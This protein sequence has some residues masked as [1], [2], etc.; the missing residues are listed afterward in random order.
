VADEL[1][2]VRPTVFVNGTEVSKA[3]A[4]AMV[5]LRVTKTLGVPSY[6]RLAYLVDTMGDGLAPDQV[7]AKLGDE[8][9]IDVTDGKATWTVFEGVVVGLGVDLDTGTSQQVVVEAYDQLYKLG[10]M[11]HVRTFVDQK[12][13]DAVRALAGDAGLALG[14][15]DK[16]LDGGVRPTAYQYGTAYAYIDALV[17]DAGCE[18]FVEAKKLEVR[19]RSASSPTYDLAIGRNLLSFNSR[20]SATEHVGEVTVTGWDVQKKEAI[21]GTAKLDWASAKSSIG[22]TANDPA[23]SGGIGGTK[24]FA[25]PRPVADQQDA[26][27]VAKGILSRRASEML[28]ARGE[29]EPAKEL[30]PGVLLNVTGFGENWDGGYYCTGIEHVWGRGSFR[31]FFEVGPSEPESLVDLIGGSSPAS[32]TNV[33]AGLT[34]G[35]VTNN[36]DPDKLNRVKVKLPYL[37]DDLET[38]WARVVQPGAGAG[39][40][41][42]SVLPEIDDEVLVGFEHGNLDHPFV[43]GGLFNGKDKPKYIG[44]SGDLIDGGKVAARPFTSRLGHEIFI[45]DGADAASQYVSITTAEAKAELVLGEEKITVT[46]DGMPITVTDGKGTIEIN[47]KGEMTLEGKKLTIDMSGDITLKGANINAKA[48]SGLKLEG[49][50]VDVKGTAA[51]T[52]DGG[53]STTIKGGMVSIN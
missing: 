48:Q 29:A 8:L 32:A 52:V 21:V 14:T 1:R 15:V 9:K 44:A 24:A 17:R 16:A 35:I 25:V 3:W 53:G 11:T 38:G 18:W 23:T 37:S 30:T 4:D 7:N 13:S 47:G 50:Q 43:L 27:R 6:T 26:V 34:I 40:R 41:G 39:G 12:P 20:L 49:T 31:T 51:A 42:W 19:P 2:V 36:V 28:R 33:L 5:D 46:S 45:S 22:L 10:R